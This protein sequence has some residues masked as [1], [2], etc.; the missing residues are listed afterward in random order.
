MGTDGTLGEWKVEDALTLPGPRA[1]ASAVAV[2]DGLVVVGGT[3]G[4]APT[5][6]VWKSLRDLNGKMAAWVEQRP[7]VEENMDGVAMRVGDVIF[8]VGG[9]N[10]S[11][12]PVASVQQGLVGGGPAATAKDPNVIE[13][14]R[15]SE[16]TNLPVARSNM[17]GFTAN[18]VLYVQ[19]GTDAASPQPE[20]WWAVPN[21]SGVIPAWRTLPQLDLGQGLDG[22]A[23]IASSSNGFVLGGRTSDGITVSAARANLAPQAPFF[24]IG[25]LGATIP[26]LK[27]DGETGQQIGYLLAATVGAVNF[28]L[29]LLVGWGFAHPDRV[30]ELL[31]RRR[32]RGGKG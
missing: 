1:G 22:A 25:I 30:R 6:S 28:I 2:S 24:Q 18:G 10:L 7:M 5:K 29:L 14:W 21:A 16:Q 9:R 8:V 27:L 31:A 15:L 3:D 26:G 32:R 4:T 13:A 17:A 23:G 20:T 12:Q 19:G 11:G